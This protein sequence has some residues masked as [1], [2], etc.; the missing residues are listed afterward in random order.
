M[1]R[2]DDGIEILKR[3]GGGIKAVDFVDFESDLRSIEPWC[4][5]RKQ[6]CTADGGKQMPIC[7]GSTGDGSARGDY[8]NLLRSGSV[9]FIIV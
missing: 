9:F 5:W 8:R 7:V 3:H 2:G 6:I 1:N 4:D